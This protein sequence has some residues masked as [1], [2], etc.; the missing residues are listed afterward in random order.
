V[1]L[2]NI[3][4]VQPGDD[5]AA[6]ILDSLH[7]TQLE[8]QAGDVLVITSKI[9]S[10]TENRYVRLDTVEPGPEARQLAAEIGKDPRMVE[11]VLRESQGIS[12]KAPG[13]LVTAH[14]LGFVSA[15]AGI[16]HSNTGG[17]EESVLLMPLDPEATAHTLRQQ[18]LT[19]TGA[20][21]GI[22]ISDSHGRPFRLG[23]VGV[24][25]GVAGLP[26]LLDL[27]GQTDLF[28]R[29]L[30]ISMQGYADMIASAAQLIG[31]EA[32]EGR[33]VTLVRG[34]QYPAQMGSVRDL[35]RPVDQ[36]LYR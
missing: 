15:N 14:R 1:A 35:L 21:V 5:L 28:G 36:D 29:E 8:L 33:P 24:A 11:L 18:L 2:P 30:R 31:G 16:D 7:S 10:K 3:P 12:R 20:E 25:I 9:V 34:L 4:L 32:A 13:V 26:A 22:V 27:R 23:T 19:A 17:D 6:M